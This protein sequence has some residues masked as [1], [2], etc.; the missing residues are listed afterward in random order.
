MSNCKGNLHFTAYTIWRIRNCKCYWHLWYIVSYKAS[1]KFKKEQKESRPGAESSSEFYSLHQL[2]CFIKPTVK[3]L[4]FVNTYQSSSCSHKANSLHLNKVTS[5][6][7]LL[8]DA[9][10]HKSFYYNCSLSS[11]VILRGNSTANI[12]KYLCNK[13]G[14]L[15]LFGTHIK[16]TEPYGHIYYVEK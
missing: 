6:H 13:I 16:S 3:S 2:T 4:F 1:V 10:K 12:E 9:A 15:R 5:D 14:G 7:N 11:W 8:L